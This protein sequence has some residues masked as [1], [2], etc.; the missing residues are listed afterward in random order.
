VVKDLSATIKSA[1]LQNRSKISIANPAH[2]PYGRAAQQALQSLQLWDSV[3][4]SV[5][6]GEQVSQ[7]TQFVVNG[8]V[9]YGLVSLTLA[10]APSVKSSTEYYL[11]DDSLHE[12]IE[13]Q[14]VRLSEKNE[15]AREFYNFVLQSPATEKIFKRYGLR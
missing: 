10:L 11:V 15:E 1:V 14:M 3:R 13:L 2:A 6:N 5:I 9:P 12:P 7:A 8:A 4:Q